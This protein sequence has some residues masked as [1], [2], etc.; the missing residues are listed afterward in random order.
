MTGT[1]K[2][3]ENDAARGESEPTNGAA[4]TLHA[5]TVAVA[6]RGLLIRGASGRGKSGLA[7]E[8]IARGAGLVADDRTVI[9]R[10]GAQVMADAPDTIRGRIE[11]RGLGILAAPAQ[12]PVPLALVVDMDV[13]ETDRLP[14]FRRT[15]VAGIDLPLARMCRSPHFS[16]ALLLYL[17]GERLE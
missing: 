1:D 11:A 8:L 16:S 9:W 5:T 15:T 3:P 6:G 10:A 17:S 14:P 13:E 7:L 4:Q 12:G 2:E